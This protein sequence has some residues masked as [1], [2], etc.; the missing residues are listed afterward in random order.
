ME[1]R[2]CWLHLSDLHSCK[3]KTGWDAN[4][5]LNTLESDLRS[6]EDEHELRPSFLFFTGDAAYGQLGRGGNS[7]KKQFTDAIDFL[8]SIRTLFASEV[9]K[10][11]IFVVPGNHDVNRKKVTADQTN[12]LDGQ[13]STTVEELIHAGELHWQR[14]VERLHDY[15]D[16]LKKAGYAHLLLD[17]DGLKDRLIYGAQRQI[18]GISVGIA[19]LNSAWSCCRDGEKGKLWFAHRWQVENA[20]SKLEGADLKIALVHHPPGW[21][22]EHEEP[23]AFHLVER[24]FDFCL[25]GHEHHDWVDSKPS[26]TRVAAGACYDHSAK[27]NGYN[28]VEL[29]LD[30]GCGFV[31]LRQYENQ[32]G[33][34]IPRI[35]K[36][37]TDD[38]GVWRLDNLEILGNA[39]RR[40]G[41][42]LTKLPGLSPISRVGGFPASPLASDQDRLRKDEEKVLRCVPHL[43][44]MSNDLALLMATEALAGA[45]GP[46]IAHAL[47]RTVL[48]RAQRIL[49]R[50]APDAICCLKV[51]ASSEWLACYYPPQT[52]IKD[53]AFTSVSIE[54]S[55]AGLALRE[56]RYIII[57]DLDDV[58]NRPHSADVVE[59]LNKANVRGLAV[60]P[61][62]V[63]SGEERRPVALFKVDFQKVN[64]LVDNRPT[65]DLFENIASKLA[66]A[67]QHALV[68]SDRAIEDL[69]R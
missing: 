64:Q 55:F 41:R 3:A 19:G 32:G 43:T 51:A 36:G 15:R 27:P 26:H 13:D 37:K 17:E 21:L 14:Y 11:N 67:F 52:L 35:I 68:S 16:F 10:E 66:L 61:I 45:D 42:S 60:W 34:W 56:D 63:H 53:R 4:R 48:L 28:I 54:E 12:W 30:E 44:A 9:P 46:A 6:L 50:F 39:E 8:E 62:R 18:N 5:V 29:D 31:W 24:E 2:I 7:I 69:E 57:S 38:R 22:V 58:P 25:H 65:C 47:S 23:H 59:A 40:H 1:R 49:D 33:G 20:L